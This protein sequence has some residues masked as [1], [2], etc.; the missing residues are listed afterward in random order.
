MARGLS[1]AFAG[2]K[3][4]RFFAGTKSALAI[5]ED[6]FYPLVQPSQ[7]HV[8]SLDPRAETLPRAYR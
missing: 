5:N 4:G 3:T 2:C 6:S 1:A 7:A 8:V